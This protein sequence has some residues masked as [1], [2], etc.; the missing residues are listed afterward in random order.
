MSNPAPNK[1]VPQVAQPVADVGALAFTVQALKQG[2]D[3]LAGYRG[4]ST[5]RAVTFN[6]LITLGLLQSVSAIPSALVGG[7]VGTPQQWQAGPVTALSAGLVITSTTLTASYQAGTLTSFGTGLALSAGVLT[8]NWQ[9]GIVNALSAGLS[10]V[11]T[12]LTNT[13]VPPTGAAGGDL[14]GTYPNPTLAATAVGA[15]SYGSATQSPTYTVD[16]KGRLTAAA[17]V[18]ITGTVPGGSAGG[19]LTGTYPN[20]TIGANKVTNSQL[21]QGAARTMKGVVGFSAANEADLTEAQMGG[22]IALQGYIDGLILSNDAG[23]P[24]TVFDIGIGQATSDDNAVMMTLA[25]AYT[26]TMSA[27]AVGTGNGSLDTGT[28]AATTFYYVFLIERPDTGVTDVLISVS[29]TAPTMPTNYTK[30][31]RIGALA[32]D[33]AVHWDLFTQVGDQFMWKIPL[34]SSLNGVIGV[35]TAVTVTAAAPSC[36]GLRAILQGFGADTATWIVYISP[37]NTTDQAASAT[38]LTWTGAAL[39]STSQQGGYVEV[40]L[41]SVATFRVRSFATTTT[42]TIMTLGW[43]DRRGK[44]SGG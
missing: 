42:V 19:D 14:T 38:M 17:N 3:S 35:T 29:A 16:A 31:R 8:P 40:E 6:D 27:W 1:N 23:T 15:G 13:G 20:P 18:T 44:L 22:M 43:I 24:N 9:L 33:G 12:T 34:V 5:D 32:T 26:K 28:I 39:A 10:I 36:A 41:S 4:R 37:L 30:K 21:A 2:M 11:G 7:V 25:S